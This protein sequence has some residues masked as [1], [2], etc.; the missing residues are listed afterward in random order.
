LYADEESYLK[1]GKPPW[2]RH[3][4]S[5]LW[6]SLK[7]VSAFFWR[8][9]VRHLL[10]QPRTLAELGFSLQELQEIIGRTATVAR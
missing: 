3:L 10:R 6:K 9:I 1:G 5:W 8:R 4:G 2:Y 7:G